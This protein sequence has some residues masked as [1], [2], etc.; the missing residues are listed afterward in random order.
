MLSKVVMTPHTALLKNYALTM[1][2]HDKQT[3]KA[4]VLLPMVLHQQP[5]K[6]IVMGAAQTLQMGSLRVLQPVQTSQ[7]G[8]LRVLGPVQTS[9]MAS[10]QVQLTTWVFQIPATPTVLKEVLAVCQQI[11]STGPREMPVH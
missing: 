6:V 10:L 1:P 5:S 11:S 3:G 4:T 8:S 2:Q 9:Q 7:R